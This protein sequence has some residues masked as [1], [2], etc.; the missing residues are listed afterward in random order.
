MVFGCD[1]LTVFAFLQDKLQN[2][3]GDDVE[4]ENFI[5]QFPSLLKKDIQP[6]AKHITCLP[7]EA[8]K[9]R[10]CKKK[11]CFLLTHILIRASLEAMTSCW[12]VSEYTRVCNMSQFPCTKNLDRV[13][14]REYKLMD[15]FVCL[16]LCPYIKSVLL[17]RQQPDALPLSATPSSFIFFLC[18]CF[19]IIGGE[20]DGRR[21][22]KEKQLPLSIILQSLLLLLLLLWLTRSRAENFAFL[23]V[24]CFVLIWP[25]RGRN[26]G[27]NLDTTCTQKNI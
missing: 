4:G 9:H 14:V 16:C 7:K 22:Q 23:S 5:I 19:F 2:N 3:S 18:G 21:W 13:T 25:H 12:K 10:V 20:R 11:N 17:N 8:R 6:A 24:Q 15:V 26:D 1:S 27:A